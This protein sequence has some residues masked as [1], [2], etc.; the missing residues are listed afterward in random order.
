MGISNQSMPNLVIYKMPKII[1]KIQD[2]YDR[3]VLP[4]PLNAMNWQLYKYLHIIHI[5][6]RHHLQKEHDDI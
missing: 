1:E 4:N 2:L 3:V 5:W 6:V